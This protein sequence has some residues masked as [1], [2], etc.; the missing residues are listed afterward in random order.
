MFQNSNF[1]IAGVVTPCLRLDPAVRRMTEMRILPVGGVITT[2][3]WR[4][5]TVTDSAA[6]RPAKVRRV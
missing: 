5:D 3:V 6:N 4:I 2:C 1:R